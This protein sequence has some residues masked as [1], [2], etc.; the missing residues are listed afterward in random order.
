M[1][2]L[3]LIN[4]N[5][6]F[7]QAAV[8]APGSTHDTRLLKKSSI[9]SGVIN[10]NVIPDRVVHLGDF[11]EIPLVTIGDSAFPQFACLIKA[12]N[13]NIRDNQKVFQQA[14]VWRAIRH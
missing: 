6:R 7:V 11:R 4:Y 10:G 8:G 2:N 14:I 3:G 9:Y 1:A 5:K 13:M 12:Y